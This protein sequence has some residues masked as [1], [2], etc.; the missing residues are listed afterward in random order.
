MQGLPDTYVPDTNKVA[1][2]GIPRITASVFEASSI[3]LSVPPRTGA[4]YSWSRNGCAVSGGTSFSFDIASA[5]GSDSGQFSVRVVGAGFDYPSQAFNLAVVPEVRAPYLVSQTPAAGEYG[6]LDN[7]HVVLTTEFGGFPTPTYQW[8]HNGE[9]HPLGTSNAYTIAAFGAGFAGTYTCIATNTSGTASSDPIV[10]SLVTQPVISSITSNQ[11][12]ALGSPLSLSVDATGGGLSYQWSLNGTNVPDATSSSFT[13]PAFAQANEGRYAVEVAN[14]AG[15]AVSS[16]VRASIASVN[17]SCGLI[18]EATSDFNISARPV[19]F[20]FWYKAEVNPSPG[21]QTLYAIPLT[22]SGPTGSRDLYFA[23]FGD[24]GNGVAYIQLGPSAYVTPTLASL[25][26]GAWTDWNHFVLEL[27]PSTP[28][29]FVLYVNGVKNTIAWGSS[30]VAYNGPTA[31]QLG[32]SCAFGEDTDIPSFTDCF[33]AFYG[34]LLSDAQ[35]GQLYANGDGWQWQDGYGVPAPTVQYTFDSSKYEDASGNGYTLVNGQSAN[36]ARMELSETAK[37]GSSLHM[38]IPPVAPLLTGQSPDGGSISAYATS[39]LTLSASFSGYPTPTYAWYFNSGVVSTES[40]YTF[41]VDAYSAGQYYCEATNSA[42]AAQ[43]LP[44]SLNVLTPVSPSLSSQYPY[45]GDYT[46]NNGDTVVLSA[47][48]N[49]DPAPTLEW[50]VNGTV[51][52]TGS[53]YSFTADYYTNAGSYQCT[54]TNMAGQDY[55]SAV[56]VIINPP[57]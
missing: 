11:V 17:T 44:V 50:V 33:H 41:T 32:F 49:G 10:L 2:R 25:G 8:Y 34:T 51:V 29:A 55:S 20:S 46:V 12:I 13:V 56:N 24:A 22:T 54:A 3:A 16:E 53:E 26:G 47:A 9:P 15:T 52:G 37:I 38:F 28:S 48:F 36:P 18:T 5:S 19:S 39:S 40:S 7:D 6:H 43:S 45:G 23:S 27:D 21:S 57:A 4:S 31:L 14:V 1:G 35:V 42:G 30:P